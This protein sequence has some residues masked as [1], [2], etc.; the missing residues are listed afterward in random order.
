MTKQCVI[1]RPEAINFKIRSEAIILNLHRQPISQVIKMRCVKVGLVFNLFFVLRLS[2]H[3]Q[4]LYSPLPINDYVIYGW[5]L[6]IYGGIA[7]LNAVFSFFRS[8]L[9]A[10]G[11]ICAARILHQRLLGVVLKAKTWFFDT[12]PLGKSKEIQ[13]VHSVS[14]WIWI[15]SQNPS[16]RL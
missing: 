2:N 10:Y 3:C 16:K 6:S 15:K 4:F 12:T 11:G 9:F 8:F 5:S 1:I 13:I 7:A 14:E